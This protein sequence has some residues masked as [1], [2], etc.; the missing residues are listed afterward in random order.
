MADLVQIDINV[1][2]NAEQAS[3][4]LDRLQ[5]SV[6]NNLKTVERLE[7]NYK[8]LD[9]AFNTGKITAQRYAQGISQVDRAIDEVM[10]GTNQAAAATNQFSNSLGRATANMN[11]YGKVSALG[12]KNLNRTNMIIQ[13]A[14]YQFQD[15]AVQVQSGTSAFVALGQQGSQLLGL[16]GAKGAVLGAIL[17]VGT[18]FANVSASGKQLA[19]DFRG[20][21]QAIMQRLEPIRPVIDFI[22]EGF[23]LLG[24]LAVEAINLVLNGLGRLAV[25]LGNIPAITSDMASRVGY[26]FKFIGEVA[27]GQFNFVAASVAKG[28]DSSLEF[29]L[30][31]ADKSVATFVGLKDSLVAVFGLIPSAVGDLMIQSVNGIISAIESLLNRVINSV[32]SFLQNINSAIPDWMKGEGGGIGVI[33]EINIPEITNSLAGSA[34]AAGDAVANSFSQAFSKTY[35]D[36]NVRSFDTFVAKA[37]DAYVRA[38]GSATAFAAAMNMP[39]ESVKEL[40]EALENYEDLD[41][42]DFFKLVA[43]DMKGAGKEAEKL[44]KELDQPMVSAIE[45]VSN[46]FG[47]FIARGLTD[48]KGFVQQILGSFQNMIAQMI[49]MAV[50]NRIMLSLGIGGVTPAAAAAGQVA[51]LGTATTMLGSFGAGTGIA[52]LAGGSGFLG[53]LGNAL[54]M[55]MFGGGGAGLFSIGAN[56][57]AAGGGLLATLGSALPLIG[58][59]GLAFAAFRKKVTELDNGIQ[60]VI[61]TMD[62]SI[63]SFRTIETKRF[64]GLFKKVTTE[65]QG[66]SKAASDPIIQSVREIQQSVMDAAEIFHISAD[67]FDNFTYRFKL[68]LKGLSEDQKLEAINKELT[69]MGDSF[70]AMTGY[71]ETL[72]EL[73]EAANQRMQLQ[74]RLDQVLGNSAAILARQREAELAAMHELNRPL[75]QAIYDIEDAQAA[76][77][78]AFTALQNSINKVVTDLQSKLTVANEA[79][80]RSRS[81]VNQL[82]QALSGR[83]VSGDISTTM[84]RREGALNFLR[85][86]DFSDEEALQEALGVISEPTEGLYGSFED[87]ARDFYVTSG[88]IEGAKKVAES[89]LSA[90]ERAVR[91]LEQQILDAQN[92]YQIMVDQYNALLGIDTSIMSVADAIA[93]LKGALGSL[94]SATTAVTDLQEKEKVEMTAQMDAQKVVNE[95]YKTGGYSKQADVEVYNKWVNYAKIVGAQ[96][97]LEE[98]RK[99]GNRGTISGFAQGGFHTGG[100]R[101]VGEAGPEIEMTGPSRIFSHNQTASM[102]RD[103]DLKD[104]VRSL[105]SEVAG[106]RSEQRQIQ[107]DISKYTKRSYDIERKWDVEGLPATRT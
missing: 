87:Y 84:F 24:Y 30:Q 100:I 59:I 70:A 64:F 35:I 52:G 5:G 4:S 48:F 53:G 97:T 50:K 66:L 60:G 80:N 72:N 107:M 89:Q 75:A 76:V 94:S 17:A 58:A 10:R 106:L 40:Y 25:V 55:P 105:K 57:S 65:V 14:G 32:N 79:V 18:A 103:P 61:T 104:A 37:E 44:R 83:A 33:K 19:F 6:V 68:S 92:Q 21:G 42:R 78:N 41:I 3:R 47:D 54:S 16:F 86:G 46:A 99:R 15:F 20:I 31:F 63:Q 11:Q 101:M 95:L 77:Q 34:S 8:L 39:L 51:G 27:K 102:F 82:Q 28:L 73:L 45:G 98:W 96:A 26:A 85:R 91:L 71:F 56:A 38:S 9:K 90:D 23:K 88:I 12:G 69:K 74:A 1:R 62:A 29:V 7:R 2:S 49:A 22:A 93:N 81:I 67:S 36:S 43:K 13:Q